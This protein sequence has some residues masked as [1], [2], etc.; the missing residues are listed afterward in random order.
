MKLNHTHR[1][2][3]HSHNDASFISDSRDIRQGEDTE[4]SEDAEEEK[5]VMAA[6]MV[7]DKMKVDNLML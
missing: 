1:Y 2:S 5:V 7:M 6:A 3:Y 4:E